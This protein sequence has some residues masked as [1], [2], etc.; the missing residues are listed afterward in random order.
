MKKNYLTFLLF[1][2]VQILFAQYKMPVAFVS[3]LQPAQSGEEANRTIDNNINT[4]YH[5]RYNLST[6]MPDQLSFY[7]SN[8]VK[9][10]NRLVY[11]PRPTGLNGIWTSVKI[12]YSTQANPSVFTDIAGVITWAADNTAKTIDLPT[13][14]IKPAVIKV[15]VLSAQNNFSSCAEMEFYSSEQV[16][17]VTAECTLPVSEF[18]SYNDIQVLPQVAGSSASSFQPGENIEKSFDGDTNT[19]YHSNWSATAATFPIS[20]VYRFDGQTAINYLR[21]TSRQ[22]GPNGLFGNVKISYNTISNPNYIDISTYNFGQINTIKTVVFP[23]VITPLNIKIEVLDGKNNFASCAEMEFFQTNPNSLNFSAYSNIFDDPVFSTLKPNVTQQDINAIASPF[24]K[25]LAQCL[26]N[27]TYHKKYRVQTVSAYKTLNTINVQYKVGNYNHYENPTGIAFQPNT[28]V[29]V[30]AKDITTANGVYLKIRDFATEGSSPEKS[31]ELKNGINILNISNA[32]LGYISYYTDDVSAAPVSVNI[33]GGIVNG[34]YKKGTS[35]S[36]WTEILTNDV[37]PKIDIEGYYTKLVIDKFAVSGFH[38]SNPQPLI[39]KYDA[40]TKSERE[41]MGFFTFNKNIKNR[42]L[43]YTESTGGWFAGGMG[44][45]LDLT[46]GLS[47]SASASGMDIWGVGH[48]LGHVNQIR[49]GLKWIG[50]TEITNNL[51]SLWAY[52]NLYSPAGSNRFT[53]LEGEVADK[54]AFPKVA[55]NRFGEIIIQTQINGKN[56]MDQFRTDYVNSRDGNFRSLIPFWQ[57]ELY[58]QL[59]GASKGAPRLDFDTDMSDEST[60]NPPAPVTGVDYAHWF[61]IVAE[62]VRNTDESQ[63]TQGQLVMNFVKNTCDAVQENLIDFFTNTGFLIPIDGIISDYSTAQLTITQS[64]IDDVK[65]YILSKGYAKPVSPVINYLSANSLNAFKNL[66]PVAGV[67]GVGAQITTNAQ[68]QF[69]L[70]DNTKWV[71]TVA[72]ETYDANNQMISVSIVG[73]G[74]TTL[75]KT[76]VDFPSNAQKVYAVGYNGQKILVYPAENL[77]VN[78]VDD[79]N[80]NFAISPN[81]LKNGEKMIITIKNPKG[82]LI[83]ALYDITGKL[84]ISVKGSLNEINNKINAQAQK[85]KTGIYIISINDGT[86]QYQSKIIKE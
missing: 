19:L 37:Y 30:F 18:S 65:S 84:I 44:A 34:I 42:Q 71:N 60:Q 58:Y 85:L 56:I 9:S 23:S 20:L 64:M 6:A 4:L 77:A 15:D 48:E 11:K 70:V 72:F 67:T 29:I 10:V 16:D 86:H 17:P 74:D 41:M 47:N 46:W 32:G 26:F 66:L 75:A 53:R 7:F 39:D 51:Y 59:A 83:A 81:P 78:E 8:R 22:D 79:R 31:Y 24:I 57:L 55:G 50:T 25:G 52:Y 12:S 82:N 62:K 13:S 68:G 43:V 21:Y 63:L 69:L 80:N 35:S 45:H 54:S 38:F 40:I 49:P 3:S 76:Y 33:T 28:T 73:T 27:N 2:W 1:L 36:E 14:I 5:S 61:A